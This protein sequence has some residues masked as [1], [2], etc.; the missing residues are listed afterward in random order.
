MKREIQTWWSMSVIP[1]LRRM[2]QYEQEL[3]AMLGYLVKSYPEF[4][5]VC[6]SIDIF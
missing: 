1:A 5:K 4:C 3:K 6:F 2:S